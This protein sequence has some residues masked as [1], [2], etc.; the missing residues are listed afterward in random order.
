[1]TVEKTEEKKLLG[2]DN[3]VIAISGLFI[4]ILGVVIVLATF[5]FNTLRADI[6]RVA[7]GISELRAENVRLDA[8][9]DSA[10][11]RLDDKIDRVDNKID[12]VASD[13]D[14]KIDRVAN[15]LDAKIDRVDARLSGKIDD[16][17]DSIDSRLDDTE[18]EQA[19][20]QGAFDTFSRTQQR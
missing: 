15:E 4:A 18:R 7:T 14:A 9:I 8:K 2:M 10:T 1:M 20:L 13:L 11:N 16:L 19:R 5:A 12:R 6:A 3:G 17:A